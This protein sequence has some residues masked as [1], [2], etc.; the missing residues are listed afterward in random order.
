MI[1]QIPILNR[2]SLT[3]KRRRSEKRSKREARREARRE[4][5][6]KR[7]EK[8]RRSENSSRILQRFLTLSQDPLKILETLSSFSFLFA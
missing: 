8:R 2:Q 3:E 6:E 1:S 7:E 5:K 4:A